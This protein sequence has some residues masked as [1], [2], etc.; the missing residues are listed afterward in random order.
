ML[1]LAGPVVLA[2][3][4]WMMMGI[5]DTAM[6]G[7]VS[8]EAIGGVSLGSIVFYTVAV[9]GMGVSLGLDTLVSQ[10]FGARKIADCHRSLLNSVYM[11]LPLALGMMVFLWWCAPL[12]RLLGVHPDVLREAVPYLRAITWSTLPLL[13]YFAFRRYLQGMSLVQPVM[14]ALLTANLINAAANWVLI[15]GHFGAPAMGVAGAG[16]ATTVSRVYMAAV[17]AGYIFYY[18]HRQ[19]T[20]LLHT[21]LRPDFARMRRLAE[22][23]VPAALQITLEVGVF[24]AAAALI[25][26]L[27]PVS[28]AAHQIALNIAGFTFMVPLGVGSA[29][30]VR[31]GQALGRGDPDS[32]GRS[33]WTALTLGAGFMF[34]AGVAFV[35]APRLII[36]L[37]TPDSAVRNAGVALLLIA[38]AF[39]LFDGIQVVVTGILRGAGDTH[40]PMLCHLTGYWFI[41]LPIGY[42][43]CFRLGWGAAGI[44]IG[45][46][47]A[48]ILIGVVLL[49]VWSRKVRQFA[50]AYAVEVT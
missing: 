3:L 32:A 49:A 50:Q 16:W 24:A 6:V 8:A 23:G 40:T 22:L 41:G 35:L 18:D 36:G 20:G 37:F 25:G 4:G 17:L 21:S 45:L 14:Y 46:C 26:K 5:V 13:L 34:S 15:F 1:A 9:F 42:W 19:R 30:A 39:Q 7:R 28:L 33:G 31:V 48:L 10:A 27:N 2:E 12:L 11:T 29:G 38:A 44:W 47:I 43:L